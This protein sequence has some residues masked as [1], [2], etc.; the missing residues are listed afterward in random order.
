MPK[1]VCCYLPKVHAVQLF[2][3]NKLQYH[4]NFSNLKFQRSVVLVDSVV[5]CKYHEFQACLGTSLFNCLVCT[6]FTSN[7]TRKKF[8][9]GRKMWIEGTN[10][11]KTLKIYHVPI[12]IWNI[13][14]K[15]FILLQMLS[16]HLNLYEYSF[17]PI[18][19]EIYRIRTW[20]LQSKID[21]RNFDILLNLYKI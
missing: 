14:L 5:F 3:W 9:D 18:V 21:V 19:R 13:T 10:E 7:A 1:T 6:K 2:I 12:N 16:F 4:R 8:E 20:M 11:G 17:V 15:S